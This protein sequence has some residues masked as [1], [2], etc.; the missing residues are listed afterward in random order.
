MYGIDGSTLE[1][2][3]ME[4]YNKGEHMEDPIGIGKKYTYEQITRMMEEIEEFS[5]SSIVTMD[6]KNIMYEDM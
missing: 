6:E 2:I 3:D 4:F 5:S 1:S